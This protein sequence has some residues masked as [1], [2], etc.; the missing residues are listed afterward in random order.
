MRGGGRGEETASLKAEGDGIYNNHCPL[1]VYV[2][3]CRAKTTENTV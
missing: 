3:R 2:Q 1:Q